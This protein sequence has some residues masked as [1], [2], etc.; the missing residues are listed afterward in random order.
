MIYKVLDKMW[1]GCKNSKIISAEQISQYNNKEIF[2]DWKKTLLIG[3]FKQSAL[4]ENIQ[5]NTPFGLL[6]NIQ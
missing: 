5:L 2:K 3:S 6:E 4:D 1:N